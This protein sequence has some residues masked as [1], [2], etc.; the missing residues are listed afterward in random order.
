MYAD[1]CSSNHQGIYCFSLLSFLL[2]FPSSGVNFTQLEVAIHTKPYVKM[3]KEGRITQYR[4]RLDRTL[5]SHDLSDEETLTALIKD[6]IRRSQDNNDEYQGLM[7]DTLAKRVSELSNLL[8]MLRSVSAN[9]N[10]IAHPSW[11][12][13]SDNEEFRVMYQE[14]PLGSPIHT[15][16]VEGYVDAPVDACLC[17]SWETSIYRTWF[18]ETM[19]PTFKVIAAKRLQKIRIDEHISLVRVKLSWPLTDREAVLHYFE[20]EYFEDDLVIVVLNSVPDVGNIIQQMHGFDDDE[21]SEGGQTIRIDFVGGFALQKVTEDRSYFRTIANL[22]VKLDFVPPSLINFISRQLI[23][24]GFKLYKKSVASITGNKNFVKVLN[25][26]LYKRIREGIYRKGK[27]DINLENGLVQAVPHADRLEEHDGIAEDEF[28]DEDIPFRGSVDIDESSSKYEHDKDLRTSPVIEEDEVH[29]YKNTAGNHECVDTLGYSD[30]KQRRVRLSVPVE[31]ALGTLE[32]A[33][34]M[35][36]VVSPNN[37]VLDESKSES[38]SESV[39]ANEEGDDDQ[40]FMETNGIGF[41]S[42]ADTKSSEKHGSS[43]FNTHLRR[44]GSNS[45]TKEVDPHKIVSASTEKDLARSTSDISPFSSHHIC[46]G[47][48]KEAP[49]SGKTVE[50]DSQQIMNGNGNGVVH[51]ETN[52]TKNWKTRL[53]KKRGFCCL[54][55]IFSARQR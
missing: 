39:L 13:K 24:S 17:V 41:G 23:G 50:G 31:E 40:S 26:P 2:C 36:R 47:L 3:V 21:T 28:P 7:N 35:I 37:Q 4:E 34:A 52:T 9:Y 15:L 51:D 32:K 10:D 53:Q 42:G 30:L 55:N 29:D 43:F 48:L 16:L 33:I 49:V 27:P 8:D 5:T 25:D 54:S 11:K 1:R 20:F 44:T 14:G 12:V 45:C 38:E 6:Q 19:I 46:N 22:D 18:P